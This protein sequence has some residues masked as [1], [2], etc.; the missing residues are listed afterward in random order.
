MSKKKLLGQYFTPPKIADLALKYV[1]G[2]ILSALDLAAG[3]GELLMAV[4]RAHAE[5]VLYGIDVDPAQCEFM[6]GGLPDAKIYEGDALAVAPKAAWA[7]RE[8]AFDLIVGNPPFQYDSFSGYKL[9]LIKDVL[10]LDCSGYKRMRMELSFIAESIKQAKPGGYVSIILPRAFANGWAYEQVR[11]TLISKH[12]MMYVIE[13]PAKTFSG[14]EV[15]TSI[16]VFRKGGRTAER[17]P[18]LLANNNGDVVD[19]LDIDAPMGIDRLDFGYHKWRLENLTGGTTLKDLD[20]EIVRG[21]LSL[22]AAKA[23][24]QRI[25]HTSHFGMANGGVIHLRGWAG[26]KLKGEDKWA[27]KDDFIFS[28]VGRNFG[29][30]LMIGSGKAVISDSVMRVRLPRKNQKSFRETLESGA[31]K[32]YIEAHAS[33]SCAQLLRKQDLLNLPVGAL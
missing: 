10:G 1:D 16:F 28:R 9:G 24:G 23:C 32:R 22:S 17:I 25:F 6:R 27:C 18:I 30:S 19:Q 2:P 20:P 5:S 33:G 31:F 14:T 12:S 8:G 13:I 29:D 21:D 11:K 3:E 15:K 26:E 4:R 7:D